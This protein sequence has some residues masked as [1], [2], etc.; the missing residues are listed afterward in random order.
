MP[1]MIVVGHFENF[2]P[3]IRDKTSKKFKVTHCPEFLDFQEV[4][5]EL[6]IILNRAVYQGGT[7]CLSH[8]FLL[9]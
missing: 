2:S 5:V 9:S 4:F 6:P 1:L 3:L 8:H 7:G